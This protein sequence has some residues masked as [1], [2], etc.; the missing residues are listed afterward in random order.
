VIHIEQFQNHHLPQVRELVNRHLSAVIPGW[1]LPEAYLASRLQRNPEQYVVDPWVVER[2]TLCAVESQRV[3]AA[4]HLLR[5][6]SGPEVGYDYK[7]IGDIAWLVAWPGHKEAA[8]LLLSAA[9]Q[10][11]AEWNVREEWAFDCSFPVTLVSGI[12]DVW[13]H[14]IDIFTKAGYTSNSGRQ[15]SVYGGW[16]TD[17]PLPGEAPVEG[18]IVQRKMRGGIGVGFVAMLDGEEVGCSNWGVDL[19]KGGELPSLRGWAELE[20]MDVE[21]GWRNRGIGSWLV[22]HGVEWCRLAGC[23]RVA[24]AVASEDEEAGAGRFYGRFGWQVF[25]RSQIGWRLT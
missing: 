14:I 1:A 11:M 24:F 2:K 10:Q 15:E 22:Q 3:V 12:S 20:E 16:L 13:P 8:A 21:E 17:I 25:T 5:Y 18:L 9:R 7:G 4:A 19:T 6:G 23:E